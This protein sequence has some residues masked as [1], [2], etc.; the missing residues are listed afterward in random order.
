MSQR[1]A[2]PFKGLIERIASR[3]GYIIT[4]KWR[5]ELLPIASRLRQVFEAYQVETVIDVGANEGQY[6]DF[7]RH[8]V[9]FDGRIESFEPTPELVTRLREKAAGD[10][11]WT[12]HSFALGSH[13]GTMELNLMRATVLNSFRR[14]A[15]DP[16]TFGNVVVGTVPV[17]IRTLDSVFADQG[18]LGQTYLKLDTQGYDLEV[19]RG[20]HRVVSQVSALQTEVSFV[21]LYEAMP[22]YQQAIAAFS[23]CGFA[24]A[25]MFL[26]ASDAQ[27][28]AFE[29]DCIMVRAAPK[30]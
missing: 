12:I 10:R 18:K 13:E 19:L 28:V 29:F 1:T 5:L 26:V 17:P 24:V 7:L 14:P 6:R 21:P 9:G 20:G 25:D 16:A 23:E 22:E 27:G 11:D 3:C 2:S 8:H 30:S 4:P 15:S